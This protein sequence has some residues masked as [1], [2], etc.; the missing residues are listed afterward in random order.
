[1]S[2]FHKRR[3]FILLVGII[4]LIAL[5][6]Y[7]LSGRENLTTPEKFIQDTVGWAQNIIY[8]PV[9]YV[10][11]IYGNIETLK[12]TYKENRIL[13]EKLAGY[14]SLIYEVQELKE[15]N[16]EL[17]KTLDKTDSIRDFTPIQATVISRSPER[18][19]EQV[20]INKG[21]KHG[22]RQNMAVITAD[23]MIGKIQ[24][25]SD[26]T[27]TVQLLTGFDEFN[28]IS[29]TISREKGKN[30]FGLIE[31]FDEESKSLSFKIIEESDKDLE[32][33]ELVVSSGMG[34]V[35]PKGLAI[36]KVKEV[37][38]DQYGLTRTALIEPA[39]D[40]YEINHVIVVDRDLGTDEEPEEDQEDDV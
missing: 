5:I 22:V 35:F 3:F 18:W 15:D 2:F 13:K 26:L 11:N 27:A 25:V 38:P 30:I 12:N 31:E 8:K 24:T 6:G 20:R 17:Q 39:A 36:G 9:N 14:K 29:A 21:S 4:I 37:V 40:M 33:G 28:R 16:E 23:G 7:S 32:E 19:V 10:T 34:G 1:M